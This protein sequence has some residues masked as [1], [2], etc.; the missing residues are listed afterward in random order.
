MCTKSSTIELS[1]L[2]KETF[3][4]FWSYSIY[5]TSNQFLII[6]GGCRVC[7]LKEHFNCIV[8][9]KTG[10]YFPMLYACIHAINVIY[11]LLGKL[12][13][14][15]IFFIL[16]AEVVNSSK[17]ECVESCTS[18]YYRS[19]MSLAKIP[20]KLLASLANKKTSILKRFDIA[21]E[22]TSRNVKEEI[23]EELKI[24][25]PLDMAIQSATEVKMLPLKKYFLRTH[26]R[27]VENL[28]CFNNTV[29]KYNNVIQA[30]LKNSR[31]MNDEKIYKVLF[32][33]QTI[34]SLLVN[35]SE[36]NILKNIINKN[37]YFMRAK[38]LTN[39]LID[40]LYFYDNDVELVGGEL[41]QDSTQFTNFTFYYTLYKNGD[42]TKKE[43][44]ENQTTKGMDLDV[45]YAVH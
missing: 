31:N 28:E 24:T 33:N 20:D 8:W 22:K 29:M 7:S 11:A 12:Y 4:Q 9:E 27:L 44:A 37:E 23:E 30:V 34:D 6:L 14:I 19:T 42:I 10:K 17:V 18:S 5:T 13:I 35:N 3:Q 15:L 41:T 43:W 1:A 26:D 36:K 21:M 38:N 25:R 2:V 32:L 16:G 39:Y 40:L 45:N